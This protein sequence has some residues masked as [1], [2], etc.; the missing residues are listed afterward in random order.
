MTS[1]PDSRIAALTYRSRCTSSEHSADLGGDDSCFVDLR[2]TDKRMETFGRAEGGVGRPAPNDPSSV[3]LP[4]RAAGDRGA[5]GSG[6]VSVAAPIARREGR[7]ASPEPVP[8]DWLTVALGYSSFPV[9][10]LAMA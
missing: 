7:Q 2:L 4:Q 3:A 6:R 8:E 1:L 5:G 10:R 9:T